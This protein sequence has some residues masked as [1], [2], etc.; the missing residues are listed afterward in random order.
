[1]TTEAGN[2]KGA[3]CGRRPVNPPELPNLAHK[4]RALVRHVLPDFGNW[5]GNVPDT[6]NALR[7][8]YP[9]QKLLWTTILTFLCGA[10]SRRDFRASSTTPAFLANLNWLTGTVQEAVPHPDTLVYLL[11]RLPSEALEEL[12]AKCVHTLM[13]NRVL[14]DGRLLG[15]YIIAIDGTGI[16]SSDVRHCATCLTQE[17]KD[18][19]TTYYHTVLEAKQVTPDGLVFS[20]ASE[21]VENADPNASKQDCELKALYRLLPRLKER[22]PR[23]RTCLLLDSLYANDPVLKLC[24]E[25]GWRYM[26]TFKE[27][28]APAAYA[29]FQTLLRLQKDNRLTVNHG[30]ETQHLA[31][32]TRLSWQKHHCN[33]LQCRV[34]RTTGTETCFVWITDLEL[35]PRNVETIANDGGRCRWKIENEGFNA[36]KNGEFH[37]EHPLGCQGQAWKNF[38]LL[39]QV[40]H[41]LQQLMYRWR[42]LRVVRECVGA[43]YR[44]IR[45]F[46]QDMCTLMP[47]G[48][49]TVEPAFQL[50]LDAS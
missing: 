44:F 18:G 22:F 1:M 17:H 12:S 38:Y 37:I 16:R 23:A 47:P 14:D 8:Y 21:F 5:L 4:L 28:S 43:V 31:W 35:N 46:A 24:E 50:R 48:E 39:A 45:K 13:R 6:R 49:D 34:V 10:R 26:I 7:I 2:E 9:V 32:V 29:D 40:A 25:L 36:Q 19:T 20:V 42:A 3:R 30:E 11:E 27:G 15:H 41:L 33:V